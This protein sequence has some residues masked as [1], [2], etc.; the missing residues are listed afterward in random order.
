MTLTLL[1]GY[2]LQSDGVIADQ[3][4]FLD[5]HPEARGRVRG[6][7]GTGGR[8]ALKCNFFVWDA[9]SAGGDA[10]G[11]MSDGRVPSA[12]EWADPNVNIPGYSLVPLAMTPQPGD[13][14]ANGGHVGLYAPLPDGSPGT[15]SAASLFNGNGVVHNDWGFRPGSSYPTVRR[16]DVDL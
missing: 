3:W 1:I 8:G 2:V 11:R 9:L 7:N 13:V 15:I 14:V 4:N 5:P 10:P 6:Q 16:A 12:S